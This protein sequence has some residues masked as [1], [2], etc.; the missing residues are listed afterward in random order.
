M[1]NI[2][3]CADDYGQ[4]V[5]IS[6]AIIHLI[7]KN[8]LSATSCMTTTGYWPEAAK[9]LTVYQ[10]Q[11]DV[12]L[13]F[14]LTEERIPLYK[15][16]IKSYQ[17]RLD[18][19]ALENECHAQIDAFVDQFKKLP[20]FIDGHQHIHQLPLL[21]EVILKVYQLRL[22]ANKTYIRSIYSPTDYY[23]VW[24]NAYVKRCVLQLCGARALKLK[25]LQHQ[26]PHNLS[27][28]GVHS[29][30]EN[31]NYAKIFQG[32]FKRIK[33]QGLIMCHPGLP[34]QDKKKDP[35]GVAR[36]QEYQYLGSEQFKYDCKR[37]QIKLTRGA[38][39]Y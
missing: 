5:A 9:M 34:T 15:L 16:I 28:A 13:H 18:K 8:C 3:L 6:Q 32:F 19:T 12:G 36:Y 24:G 33:N 20:D 37:Y 38:S 21:R 35:I 39:F 10:D 2:I 17:K 11:I 26:I 27:F 29:F 25:L 7:E 14:N 4:N 31:Q 22:R 1:K 23:R 30:A